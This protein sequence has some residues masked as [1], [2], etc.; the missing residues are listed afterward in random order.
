MSALSTHRDLAAWREAMQLVKVVYRETAGFPREELF[1]LTAQ[2]RR[3]AISIPS[4]LAEGAARNSP[5]ELMQ[6]LGITCGSLAE[7]ETQLKLA[8]EL[9]F[10]KP[11]ASAI[12]LTSRVGMLVRL[13][14]KSLRNSSG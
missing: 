8:V 12:D 1:G 13:L 5:G 2:I 9:G 10:L 14:R 6:Y 3:C 11:D 4:N 7:L